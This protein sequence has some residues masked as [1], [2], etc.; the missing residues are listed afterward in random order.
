MIFRSFA[1]GFVLTA[2]GVASATATGQTAPPAGPPKF[3]FIDSRIVIDKAPGRAAAEST[4][5]KEYDA[6]RVQIQK[7]QDTLQ[8]MISLYQKSQGTMTA[9]SKELKEKEIQDK[10]NLF[11]TRAGILDQQMQK[12][13]AD[14]VQ[15]IMAQVRQVLDAIRKEDS[16]T[17]IFDVGTQVGVI[18]AADSSLNITDKVIGRLKPVPVTTAK[19]DSAKTPAGAK[20]APAG[21][22]KPI[23]PSAE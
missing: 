4:F 17:F 5:Q 12:R 1:V 13:Q 8:A 10:Q 20:P 18:V 14:L 22:T 21:I 15:P 23:K 7:M 11:E 3:A 19:P 16:Y 2:S 6:A 9:V